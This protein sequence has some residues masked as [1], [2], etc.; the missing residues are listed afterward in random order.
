MGFS[1]IKGH[2]RPL[3]ILQGTIRRNRIPSALLFTG[4]SGIGKRSSALIYLQALNCLERQDG[5]ACGACT[6]CRKIASGNHPDLLSIQPD[7]GEIKIE[8]IRSVEEFLA[9]KP[10]EGRKKAVLIDEAHAM[11]INASNAFLKTLEEPP[12]DSVILL[13]TANP[14]TLPDTIRSRCFQVRFSPLPA[15][16]Y[17]AV[18]NAAQSTEIDDT[19]RRLAKGRPGL[20]LA[21]TH[22]ADARRCAELYAAMAR[23]E[24]KDAWEDRQD[25]EQWLALA[26]L[27]FRDLAVARI[28]AGEPLLVTDAPKTEDIGTVLE[29]YRAVQ[30]VQTRSAFNLNKGITWQYVSE[31]VRSKKWEVGSRESGAGSQEEL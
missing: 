30:R 15:A 22:G 1:E 7:G 28:G 2:E 26:P 31:I 27:V 10:Y 25:M 8:T 16:A 4:D 19:A 17:N 21:G 12:A 6:S 3:R 13:I 20:A 5:D 18:L 9:M 29:K 23:G 24:T 14:D 11:N